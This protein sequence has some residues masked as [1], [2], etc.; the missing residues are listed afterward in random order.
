M[1]NGQIQPVS[2]FGMAI[3][4]DAVVQ[5]TPGGDQFVTLSS[6]EVV[7]VGFGETS[8]GQKV[9]KSQV[10]D[11]VLFQAG[12][13]TVRAI[14]VNTGAIVNPILTAGVN[15]VG[16]ASF[17]DV[18]RSIAD[19]GTAQVPSIE[20]L[21]A[22]APPETRFS[23]PGP[24][25]I[26]AGPREERAPSFET[27][28]P[29]VSS[30]AGS[31]GQGPLQERLTR[32]ALTQTFAEKRG[33]VPAP[34]IRRITTRPIPEQRITAPADVLPTSPIEEMVRAEQTPQARL[35]QQLVGPSPF[36]RG[37]IREFR[38]QTGIFAIPSKLAAQA[39]RGRLQFK[40]APTAPARVVGA[41][42]TILAG[43]ATGAL[44]TITFP[45]KLVTQPVKTVKETVQS[46]KAF[47]TEP[48]RVIS[49]SPG[50][51]L[52]FAAQIGGG[53][54]T[55]LGALGAVSKARGT[56]FK[57]VAP[58]FAK[59]IP[60]EKII[61]PEALK[62]KVKAPL[63]TP[64]GTSEKIVEQALK[65][66]REVR[67]PFKVDTETKKLIST[68][69]AAPSPLRGKIVGIGERPTEAAG[70]FVA[71][72]VRGASARFLRIGAEEPSL[73]EKLSSANVRFGLLPEIKRPTITKIGL[74]DIRRLP[75]G[76][77]E[78]SIERVRKFL[79]KEA[80]KG[81][82][83]ITPK[84]EAGARAGGGVEVEAVVVPGTILKPTKIEGRV[85]KVL[86]FGEF[87]RFK[88][89]VVPV[90]RVVGVSEARLVRERRGLVDVF[91]RKPQTVQQ[92]VSSLGRPKKIPL[93]PLITPLITRQQIP[94]SKVS[95]EVS[96][97]ISGLK[98]SRPSVPKVVSV[99]SFPKISVPSKVPSIIKRL[100]SVPKLPPS[101]PK[102][103]PSALKIPPSIP[104]RIPSI[105]SARSGLVPR[106]PLVPTIPGLPP[107]LRGGL[108]SEV[109]GRG[110]LRRQRRS[111][112]PT[113]EALIR[114]IRGKR[115]AGLL[116]GLELRPLPLREKTTIG[117]GFL[118]GKSL[119][120]IA[121]SVKP[122]M[123]L[124][125]SERRELRV[126]RRET[127]REAKELKRMGVKVPKFASRRNFGFGERFLRGQGFGSFS[128]GKFKKF[129]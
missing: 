113:V 87:A 85:A 3:P 22:S 69:T 34:T 52:G 27:R 17:D 92:L 54:V 40:E 58:K 10:G 57:I 116:T 39:E 75:V 55:Q 14:N 36:E 84:L 56:A 53:T 104:K 61:A 101:G 95:K 72:T 1:T 89:E 29:T 128:F 119:Q 60:S 66:F 118:E 32:E 20:Q 43:A 16:L 129:K 86:G 41:G 7:P 62:T 12:A 4:P 6:G 110:G 15:L 97:R 23:Q 49:E 71:P 78:S 67:K 45:F 30:L 38:P 126:E 107:R 96:R 44:S 111:F 93:S 123:K 88:G 65:E 103:P 31:T 120:E 8:G 82:A 63:V 99:S 122:R 50:G 13:G 26:G 33:Q 73:L 77:R 18:Q 115:P 106:V 48:Q 127:R 74:S 90:R 24:I 35:E 94:V 42:K 80:P 9:I 125:K 37:V 19:R 102:I 21:E 91:R 114:G 68:I 76:I 46:L 47:V 83:F 5:T 59:E 98:I 51:A 121:R 70:L 2:Q 105:T 109:G 28:R 11:F 124:S 81:V 117:I 64:V 25:I 108:P 79:I 112:A 100:I